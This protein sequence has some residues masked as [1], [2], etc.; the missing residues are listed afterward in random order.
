MAICGVFWL[1]RRRIKGFYVYSN[2]FYIYSQ[3]ELPRSAAF[4]SGRPKAGPK[5]LRECV[6]PWTEEGMRKSGRKC[7]DFTYATST[8][9]V[10]GDTDA[11]LAATKRLVKEQIAFYAS[12]RTYQPVLS[13]HGWQDIVPH[14]HRKSVGGDWE[15]MAG[16]ITDEMVDTYAVTGTYATIGQKIRELC[17]LARPHGPL[18]D[19]PAEP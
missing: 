13:T 4:F 2:A 9:V 12:T 7:G 17:K 18:S 16:L 3:R 8:F 5:Y 11:E 14:L 1:L 10:V 15:G 6:L 19:T